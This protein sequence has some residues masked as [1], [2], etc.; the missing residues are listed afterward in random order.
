VAECVELL[1]D[2]TLGI[3]LG[4]ETMD[5]FVRYACVNK[6]FTNHTLRRSLSTIHSAGA[7][8]WANLIVGLPFL[9]RAEVVTGT[10][11]S[12][13]DALAVGFDQVVLFPNHV[14]E[15]T[16]AHLLAKAGR[17]VPPDLWTV[18]DVLAAVSPDLLAKVHLAWVD[19]K[20]HPGAATVDF[21]PDPV[22]TETLRQ[23][24][25]R[26]NLDRDTAAL[27]EALELP[28][29]AHPVEESDSTLAQRLESH[30]RW[31][32]E[33]QGEPGWW[34]KHGADVVDELR[35]GQLST[36]TRTPMS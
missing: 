35:T 17:Y 25:E 28:G 24:L 9:T 16:I 10:A 36:T 18:R 11:R 26:F 2:R 31:L 21:A 22:A 14:K 3:E 5:E 13:E 7:R 30:Y 8:A 27:L 34:D 29:P 32:A 33:T 6:P 15:H 4:V 19:L 23:L 20:P 12:I 1:G